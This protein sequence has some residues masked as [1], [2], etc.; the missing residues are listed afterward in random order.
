MLRDPHAIG[1]DGGIR[2]GI[3]NCDSFQIG[4]GKTRFAFN[5]FPWGR[6]NVSGKGV[7]TL[8]VLSNKLVVQHIALLSLKRQQML[9]DTFQCGGVASGFNL[10]IGRRNIR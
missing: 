1:D 10:K 6:G 4:S 3:R 5:G 7:K 8:R 9:C 2:F